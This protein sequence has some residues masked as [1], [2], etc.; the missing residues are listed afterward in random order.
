MF[1]Y[2]LNSSQS[3]EQIKKH[4]LYNNTPSLHLVYILCI[5]HASAG[6]P[7]IRFHFMLIH[8]ISFIFHHLISAP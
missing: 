3:I 1:I 2:C 7:Q 5:V 8:P 6:K 4:T